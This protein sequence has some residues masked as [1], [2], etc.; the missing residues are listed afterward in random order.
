MR[1]VFLD[2]VIHIAGAEDDTMQVRKAQTAIIDR[3]ADEWYRMHTSKQLLYDEIHNGML[4][5][6]R[7]CQG[8]AGS[9]ASGVPRSVDDK[10]LLH[11]TKVNR[12]EPGV[13]KGSR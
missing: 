12:R 3:M 1:P 4:R 11:H 8:S 6:D 9:A 10:L 2:G 5:N 7:Y 13:T